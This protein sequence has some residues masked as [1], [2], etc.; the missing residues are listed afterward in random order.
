MTTGALAFC[1]IH[2]AM[3]YAGKT[4]PS[5]AHGNGPLRSGAVAAASTTGRYAAIA[6]FRRVHVSATR[7]KV[8]FQAR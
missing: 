5:V 4:P 1:L 3:G 2:R 6:A 7:V 8:R